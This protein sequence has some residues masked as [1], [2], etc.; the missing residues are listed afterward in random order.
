MGLQLPWYRLIERVSEMV[1]EQDRDTMSRHRIE[2]LE[3]QLVK[4]L[5]DRS[6]AAKSDE[7]AMAKARA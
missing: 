1:K 5:E 3:A 2:E 6:E 7:S 4:L